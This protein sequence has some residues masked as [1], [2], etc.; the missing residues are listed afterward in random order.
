MP[1]LP[2]YTLVVVII[3]LALGA[4]GVVV[5]V[6]ALLHTAA[7]SDGAGRPEVILRFIE[8]GVLF[9]AS[10]VLSAIAWWLVARLSESRRQLQELAIRDSLTG[11][12]N[13]RYFRDTYAR[14]VDRAR[15]S[16]VPFSIA[17]IDFDDF[18]RVNDTRGHLAGD[19]VLMSFADLLRVSMRSVDILARYGGDEFVI[20]MPSTSGDNARTALAR[21]ERNL[22]QWRP[23]Q[24]PEGLRV[25]IGVSTWD[26]MTE[27]LEQ[28]DRDMY[29]DKQRHERNPGRAG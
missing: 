5:L 25:S 1:P 17:M 14:E 26:G 8:L 9:T 4:S 21:L 22:V 13:R 29:L 18:K 10:L 24:A 28:A 16:D 11:L 6:Q 12:F 3:G 20:L 23:E 19:V 7:M 15:R 2:R 27:V